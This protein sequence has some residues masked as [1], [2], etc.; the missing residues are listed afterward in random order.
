MKRHQTLRFRYGAQR[1][2]W[3]ILTAIH[4]EELRIHLVHSPWRAVR[5][6]LPKRLGEVG[7]V[8]PLLDRL[9][10]RGD[11]LASLENLNTAIA[12]CASRL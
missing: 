4:N 5:P 12:M 10:R 9:M 8:A 6:K 3:E 1:D 2:S 11:C 7:V